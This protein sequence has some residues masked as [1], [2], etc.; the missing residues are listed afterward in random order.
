MTRRA[1][2]LALLVL[3]VLAAP[4]AA[5]VVHYK[6]FHSPTG[7]IRCLLEKYGGR[8]IECSAPYLPP[9]EHGTDPYYGLQPRGEA[10]VAERGD[11][12]GYPNAKDRTLRYGDTWNRRGIRCRMRESGLTCRNKDDHGFHMAKGDLRTF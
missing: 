12:P 7:Q 9:A 3:C 11:F 6:R 8:G 1:S 4:A 2:L 10:I 5:K